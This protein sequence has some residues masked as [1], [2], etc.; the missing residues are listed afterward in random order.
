M[1][2]RRSTVDTGAL[3]RMPVW[4]RD[5]LGGNVMDAQTRTEYIS[6]LRAG[7]KLFRL[8][9]RICTPTTFPAPAW[10][11]S[12]VVVSI[13]LTGASW[14]RSCLIPLAIDDEGRARAAVPVRVRHP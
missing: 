5:W 2:S 10:N 11:R 1:R 9:W 4:D 6:S 3:S 13:V 14:C 8:P 7:N 12:R